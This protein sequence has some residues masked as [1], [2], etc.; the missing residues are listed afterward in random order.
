MSAAILAIVIS[1]FAHSFGPRRPGDPPMSVRVVIHAS[2]FMGWILL[3]AIQVGLVAA[4]RKTIHRRLGIAGAVVAVAMVATAIPLAVS[5][6]SRG[7]FAGDSLAFLFVILMDLVMFS[8]F[9]GAA[10]HFR[11][12]GDLHKRLMLLGT[13]S[14]LPPAISRWPIAVQHP[15]VIPL[16]LV[17]LIAASPTADYLAGRPF[18]SASLWGGIALALSVPLRFAFANTALWHS[19]ARWLTR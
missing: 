4:Q 18:R 9:V 3:F 12:R 19:I 1:G 17:P 16:V 2:L 14:L 8:A 11:R 13:I 15:W 5:A 7:V 10:L 6:A